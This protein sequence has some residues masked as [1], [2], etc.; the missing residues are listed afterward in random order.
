MT[1]ELLD[2]ARLAVHAAPPIGDPNYVA[3][4]E[5]LTDSLTREWKTLLEANDADL[6]A[7]RAAGR[8]DAL[9]DRVRL[10]DRHLDDMRR[11]AEFV[12]TALTRELPDVA[13]VSGEVSARRIRKPL[14]VVFMIYEARPTV[15]VE[16]ALLPVVMG[17]AVILRGGSEIAATNRAFNPIVRD[18][19]RA[20]GLPEWLAQVLDDVDRSELRALLKRHDAID[21]L[22]P[23]GSPSLVDFCGSASTIPVIASG[24]GVNHL[25]VHE[26]ADLELAARIVLD[27][28]MPEPTACNT[29]E[30]VLCDGAALPALL[31]TIVALAG[32]HSEHCTVKVPA[33]LLR[34]GDGVV[35]VEPYT[36]HDRGR[37]FLDRTV[38][39]LPVTGLDEAVEFIRTYGTGHTEGVVA[40]DMAVGSRF[41]ERVDAAAIVVNGS[42]RLH[43][44]PTMGL[45]PEIAISTGRLHVR[46]PVDLTALTTYSWV[47][48]A[49]GA[50]R[51]RTADQGRK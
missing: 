39:L 6:A 7:M 26:S 31:D 13:V 23:R 40:G 41:C 37:E 4:C 14:G 45:G 36:E 44:G 25:Y 51:G 50:L 3:Y 27:S 34:P 21:A 38:G 42:L 32:A 20:A 43:D 11:L 46:G 19:L 28:K 35:A 16:G 8:P 29:L 15:T 47:I 33:E 9:V 30:T 48:E 22:V 12:R 18:S 10:T 2:R 17:N 49:A 24:G 5:R 1:D